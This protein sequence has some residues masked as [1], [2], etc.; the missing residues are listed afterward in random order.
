MTSRK[1]KRSDNMNETGCSDQI[2]YLFARK[3]ASASRFRRVAEKWQ[4]IE[5]LY[6]DESLVGRRG[7]GKGLSR[8]I[9]KL[10]P[11]CFLLS[12]EYISWL[13]G[14]FDTNSIAEWEDHRGETVYLVTSLLQHSCLPNCDL[15]TRER[16]LTDMVMGDQDVTADEYIPKG[17]PLSIT[18][19]GDD[20]FDSPRDRR[21]TLKDGWGFDCRCRKCGD[22]QR[23]KRRKCNN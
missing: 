2:P 6:C 18:Y 16:T 5:G 1:R 4:L 19:L 22:V 17:R 3:I 12:P 21:M 9:R 7:K 10:I 23:Q 11:D 20:E 15:D 14:V 13:L 8:P